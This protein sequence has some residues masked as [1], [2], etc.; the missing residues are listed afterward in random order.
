VG[1]RSRK[2]KIKN[3]KTR[4]V[5]KTRKKTRKVKKTRK[6]TRKVKKTRKKTRKVKKTR[7]K[8]TN[9]NKHTIKNDSDG[10]TIIKVSESW[11]NQALVNKSKYQKKYSLSLKE[12]DKFWKKEGKRM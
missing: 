8:I 10:N 7:K 11:S 3:K 9:F 1:K 2:N 4:K 6:K 5:K 12:N